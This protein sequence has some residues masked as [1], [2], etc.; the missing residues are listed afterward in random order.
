MLQ[1]ANGRLQ[2]PGQV[3]IGREPLPRNAYGKF[4]KAEL[5]KMARALPV[6]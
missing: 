5:R 6:R 4:L 3:V 1:R 2:V